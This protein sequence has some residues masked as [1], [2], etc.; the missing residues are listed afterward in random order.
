MT[1]VSRMSAAAALA[2][3]MTQA[4]AGAYY[5]PTTLWPAGLDRTTRI[6]LCWKQGGFAQESQIILNAIRRTWAATA[7]ISVSDGGLCTGA[8]GTVPVTILA[9]GNAN[10]DAQTS[11]LGV[12]AAMT[13]WLGSPLSLD[14][15]R[16]LAV[17]EFGHVLGLQHEQDSPA[18][19]AGC[20]TV[21]AWA[22]ISQLGGAWDRASVMNSGCNVLGNTV[23]YLS[24]GD[25]DSA[26]ALY[27]F[28]RVAVSGDYTGRGTT[29]WATWS[30]S[31]GWTWDGATSSTR[32]GEAGDQPVPGDYNGDGVADIAVWRPSTGQWWIAVPEYNYGAV[33]WGQSGDVPVPADYNG[34]GKT[35]IAVF[36]PA[37]Q[38]WWFQN[39]MLPIVFGKSTDVP[40]P[41]DYD[42]DGKA[43]AAVWSPS[44]G[45]WTV[46]LPWPELQTTFGQ[47]G[48]IPLPGDYLGEGRARV[49]VYR[50]STKCFYFQKPLPYTQASTACF[51]MALPGDIPVK[52]R[53]TGQLHDE[54]LIFRPTTGTYFTRTGGFRNRGPAGSLPVL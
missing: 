44:T 15:L 35:D 34:D 4:Q 19:D 37:T 12:G 52:G 31:V 6:A 24:P 21:D 54:P 50:P 42:G 17:H 5:N 9:S 28:R 25:A 30:P 22:D 13:F 39:G 3:L 16:Y 38:Q 14:R 36:R 41:A 53:V 40:V 7:N 29:D 1:N 2:C 11:G 47:S 43:D 26:R 10:A 45:R 32:W 46:N 49:A 20:S 48:D 23:G 18:R 27:G 8:A 33:V 51:P